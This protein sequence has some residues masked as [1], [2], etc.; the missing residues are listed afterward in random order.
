MIDLLLPMFVLLLFTIIILAIIRLLETAVL[1][2]LIKSAL[3]EHPES[4]PGLAAKIGARRPQGE[5]IY[6][7]VL[8]ALAVGLV[9]YASVGGGTEPIEVARIAIIPAIVGFAIIAYC[10]LRLRQTKDI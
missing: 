3:R 10:R 8:I 7:W 5:E 4:V 1:S 6:G 2:R 9:A